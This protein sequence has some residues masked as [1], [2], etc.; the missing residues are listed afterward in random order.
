MKALG[1]ATAALALVCGFG[2]TALGGGGGKEVDLGGLKSNAPAGWKQ[3]EPGNKFR[4][5]QFAVPK[6]SGDEEDGELTIFY[7]QG[8]GGSTKDNINRWKGM[9]SAPAGKSIDDVAKV[10]EFKVG[11]VPVTYLDVTGT[12]SFK[13]PPFSPTAKLVRKENYRML[14]VVFDNEKGP[15]FIRLT[16]PARTVADAKQ[17]FDDWIKG[18]K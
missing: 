15:Y 10:E 3:Q 7:F 11:S 4:A 8:G 6:A 2:A 9:F 12:Y 16:G 1:L 13:S 14:G 5:Y 18:F 17:G